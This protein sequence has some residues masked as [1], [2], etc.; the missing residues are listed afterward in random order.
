MRLLAC[1]LLIAFFVETACNSSSQSH[2]Q[3]GN[4][5]FQSGNYEGAQLEYRTSITKDPRFG[6][7]Y[8]RFGLTEIQLGDG[9]AALAALQRA[10]DFEPNSNHDQYR[11]ALADL[12]LEAYQADRTARRFYD[13]A[14]QEA[15]RLLNNDPNSVDGLRLRGELLVVDRKYAEALEEFRKADAIRPLDPGVNAPMVGVLFAQSRAE[16]AERLA[17]RVLEA[18]RDSA[19]LYD[20]LADYYVKANRIADAE[21]LLESQVTAL[22]KDLGPRLALAMLY[23]ESGRREDMVKT[24]ENIRRDR[25]LFPR[26]PGLAGD[27]YASVGEWEEAL[28]QYQDGERSDPA[29]RQLYEKGI[30]QALAAVGKPKEAISE[31]SMVLKAHPDDVSARLT[32]ANLLMNSPAAGDR[33]LAVAELTALC[34]Q[35]PTDAIARYNLGLAYLAKGDSKAAQKELKIAAGL[36]EDYPEPR[37][38]LAKLAEGAGDHAETV[39]L[40]EQI[41]AASPE[42]RDTNAALFHAFGLIGLKNY[43]Q[44]RIELGSILKN[45][46]DSIDANL[47]LAVLYTSEEKYSEAEA[48]YRRLYQPGSED[49]RPLQGLVQ[50]YLKQEHPAK[51]DELLA[52]ELNQASNPPE[53]RL[54]AASIAMQEGKR[55]LAIEHYEWL[56]ANSPPSAIILKSLGDLYSQDGDTK[57]A[58]ANYERACELAPRDEQLLNDL[59]VSQA[60]A[61]ET[62]AA[63]A[64]LKRQLALNPDDA[65][66]MN[67]LAFDLA[68]TGTDLD[69]AL[70][71]AATA[72]RKLSD[73]PGVMDTLGWVYA[74]KGLNESAVQ[75]FRL[76]VKKSPDHPLY[77]YHFGVVLL[78][79]N[80]PSEAKSEFVTALSEKPSKELAQQIQ[81]VSERL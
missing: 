55:G 3:R 25:A 38:Q 33:D 2:L 14:S 45:Q 12:D 9:S 56:R 53:V 80:K 18:H 76:L 49:I 16:E 59:A 60:D 42:G 79:E 15:S 50:L 61:G 47:G 52:Q 23:R 19:P 66:A 24:L 30:A 27:F 20:L 58:I 63:I 54:L 43:S 7:A 74:K 34:N 21:R 8:Y 65:V 77:H 75:V 69:R 29:D 46:P 78:Q 62:Q 32:R 35:A 13:Q 26:A 1:A 48:L 57:R 44:A 31:L 28:R 70:T 51:A 68:E 41:R 73:D 40:T 36:R 6:E 17:K 10:I 37:I 39:R 81:K 5:L 72:V 64:T 11:I 67:N 4:K 22:P 71:L